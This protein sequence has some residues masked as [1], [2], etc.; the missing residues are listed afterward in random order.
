[1]ACKKRKNV[2]GR[3]EKNRKELRTATG[4]REE[5]A[6]PYENLHVFRVR[7]PVC[8]DVSEVMVSGGGTK[9]KTPKKI[10]HEVC[11]LGGKKKKSYGSLVSSQARR[12]VKEEEK[13]SDTDRVGP[14]RRKKRGQVGKKTQLGLIARRGGEKKTKKKK[15]VARVAQDHFRQKGRWKKKTSG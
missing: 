4:K 2:G 9:E 12:E 13:E 7:L 10:Q 1:L 11:P 14:Q 8:Y 3:G 5:N 15:R 6:Q